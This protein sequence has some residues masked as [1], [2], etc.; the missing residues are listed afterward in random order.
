MTRSLNYAAIVFA[1]IMKVGSQL[2]NAILDS[3]Q[4]GSVLIIII[5]TIFVLSILTVGVL[6]LKTSSTYSQLYANQQ[7]RA[8][9]LAEAGGRYA[10]SKIKADL[11]QAQTDLHDKEFQLG[12]SGAKF[13]I[14]IDT[15]TKAPKVLVVATGI[16]NEGTSNE[17]RQAITYELEAESVFDYGLFATSRENKLEK[18]GDPKVSSVIEIG[19]VGKDYDGPAKIDYFNSDVDATYAAPPG[20]YSG[21]PLVAANRTEAES[22]KLTESAT[23]Y[24]DVYAGLGGNTATDITL[25]DFSE[26]KGDKL[27]LTHSRAM[28][29]KTDPGGGTS[30]SDILLTGTDSQTLTAGTYRLNEIELEASSTITISGDVTLIVLDQ[31]QIKD[32]GAMYIQDGG[33]LTIYATNTADPD[34]DVQIKIK[35]KGIIDQNTTPKAVDLMIYGDES[36][37]K[38]EVDI[39]TADGGDGKLYGAIYAPRAEVKLKGHAQLFGAAVGEKIKLEDDSAFHF[40]KALQSLDSSLVYG[41]AQI[42][43]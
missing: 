32:T 36:C 6:N 10:I 13:S 21:N 7:K 25:E 2:K 27:T 8:Y 26:I 38:V 4:S 35:G 22:I 5:S 19:K 18:N 12:S 41:E 11:T 39:D 16:V 14:S 20:P 17:T 33:S 37:K 1:K 30:I 31:M 15:A 40:D 34:A 3:D 24:G 43:Y 23:V 42:Q 28:A 9:S 29:S